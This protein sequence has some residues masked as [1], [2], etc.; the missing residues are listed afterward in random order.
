MARQTINVGTGPNSKN[1]DVLR[2]AFIKI[3]ENFADLYGQT[4]GI[5]V[6]DYNDLI[7]IPRIDL[8]GGSPSEVYLAI[9][10]EYDGGS[11]SSIYIN[12]LDGGGVQ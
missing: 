9:I 6:I 3:N 12:N 8:D 11:T 7:N 1:G 10:Q 5:S 4:L 2:N